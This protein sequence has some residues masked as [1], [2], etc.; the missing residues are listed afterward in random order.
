MS[1]RAHSP[2]K[3]VASIAPSIK[4]SLLK[5]LQFDLASYPQRTSYHFL[6]SILIRCTKHHLMSKLTMNFAIEVSAEA[7]PLTSENLRRVLTSASS[8]DPQQL[9]I[10]AQQLQ[11]WEKQNGYYSSLQVGCKLLLYIAALLMLDPVDV[12][13][14]LVT[15]GNSLSRNYH[16]TEWHRQILA[17]ECCKCH[18]CKRKN[19]D[20]LTMSRTRLQRTSSSSCTT[21]CISGIKN[22][23]NRLSTGMV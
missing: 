17:E 18:I 1:L 19:F 6:I 21:E 10:S 8:T 15:Y 16:I 20:S 12:H 14:S 11:N 2:T 7:N 3:F 5:V 9:K 22:N 4:P 23:S 13:R